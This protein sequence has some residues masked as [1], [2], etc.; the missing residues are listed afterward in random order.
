MVRFPS[1]ISNPNIAR[2]VP[3]NYSESLPES[4]QVRRDKF[5]AIKS[6]DVG[7]PRTFVRLLVPVISEGLEDDYVISRKGLLSGRLC[8][9]LTF[10]QFLL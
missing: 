9:I 4:R 3:T 6:I 7:L 10:R 8:Y 2:E 1:R 5:D